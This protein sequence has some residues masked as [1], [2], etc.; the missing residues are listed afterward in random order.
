MRQGAVLGPPATEP[1][2]ENEGDE[3]LLTASSTYSPSP[4]ERDILRKWSGGTRERSASWTKQNEIP[5]DS[6]MDVQ[7]YELENDT[8]SDVYKHERTFR[9]RVYAIA[10]PNGRTYRMMLLVLL[11]ATAFGHMFNYDR[12]V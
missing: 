8:I 6:T 10:D 9:S 3:A 11:C 12:F 2:Y 7:M 5:L 1:L 4:E